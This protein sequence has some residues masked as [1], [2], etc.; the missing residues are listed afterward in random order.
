VKI[1]VY[2]YGEFGQRIIGNLINYSGFCISCGEAC[3]QCRSG[4]YTAAEDIVAIIEMPNPDNLGDF[5]DEVDPLIP[6]IPEAE[7][8]VVINVHADILFGMLPLLKKAGYKAMVG[9]S[10]RPQELPLGLRKQLEDKAQELGLEAAF[11]KPFC[12]M[13]PDPKKPTIFEFL[14]KALIG[15]PLLDIVLNEGS[16]GKR[17]IIA[18]NVLRSAPC[19]STWFV[20]KR[21]TGLEADQEDL[22]ERISEA[23]HAYPCTA[24]MERDSELGDT[25]LH[26]AG[27][28]IREKVEEGIANARTVG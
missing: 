11:T 23:H 4:K 16:T 15:E 22:R 19:G 6:Q 8:A 21:L 27:Y 2:H 13:K 24:S 14:N 5:I 3:T 18:A 9:C 1:V 25:I 10:E 28:I 7:V 17:T 12:A 20:A 26:K